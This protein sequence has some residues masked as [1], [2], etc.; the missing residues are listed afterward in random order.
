MDFRERLD[1][2]MNAYNIQ[3]TLLAE[4]AGLSASYISKVR[5]GERTPRANSPFYEKI[6][7]ALKTLKKENPQWEERPLEE[8]LT[9]LRSPLTMPLNEDKVDGKF[10][11]ELNMLM[12][13]FSVQNKDLALAV[14]C[15]PSLISLYRNGRRRPSK[16]SEFLRSISEYFCAL[17]AEWDALDELF[18]KLS[19]EPI[20]PL[21]PDL[22]VDYFFE[23]LAGQSEDG[24]FIRKLLSK[25]QNHVRVSPD[26]PALSY[27]LKDAILPAAEMTKQRGKKGLRNAVLR[28]LSLCAKSDE[29]LTIKLF[30][31]QQMDWMIED[32]Q[33]FQT[34]QALMLAV[35]L[36]GH[37]VEIVHHLNRPR[38][39]L[40][41]AIE[42]WTPLHLS[43]RIHSY[44]THLSDD[45]M[46]SNTLFINTDHFCILGN[47]VAG[48]E[49]DTDYYFCKNPKILTE[50]QS[51]FDALREQAT[52]LLESVVFANEEDFYSSLDILYNPE[53]PQTRFF[54]GDRLPIWTMEPSL[55]DE[56]LEK[57][58]VPS[59]RR[60]FIRSYTEIIRTRCQE[61]LQD[62][63]IF[64]SFNV[65]NTLTERPLRLDVVDFY[66]QGPIHYEP[67]DFLRHLEQTIALSNAQPHYRVAIGHETG[68]SKVR[69][70]QNS[71]VFAVR[72][73]APFS[74]IQYENDLIL[75]K[76]RSYA[77]QRF[78]K[79]LKSGE[80][81]QQMLE[82][83]RGEL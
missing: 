3:N 79:D 82:K 1:E 7:K 43:G 31:N 56:I 40:Y 62:A 29:P 6:H 45:T 70:I 55:L 9:L 36:Q 83:L 38:E 30:S 76:F 57:N 13:Y 33:F 22:A 59:R 10:C 28:F 53:G 64:E 60:R 5:R 61:I 63:W 37:R 51:S 46:F 54:L 39:E 67:T 16:D 49:D 34:W 17:A 18:A 71:G 80:Q 8:L 15:D 25:L 44:T 11:A 72:T 68:F 65:P 21:P 75:Q 81:L 78:K 12:D 74:V 52:S 47:A 77:F 24:S 35:L 69:I 26:N 32:M 2:V 41:A 27:L 14:H 73:H 48:M 42:G 50:A 58:Q 4:M 23:L 19:S 66:D 20:D